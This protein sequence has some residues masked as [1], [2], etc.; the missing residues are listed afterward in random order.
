[1]HIC[2]SGGLGESTRMLKINLVPADLMQ[3]T[4]SAVVL[5]II[6]GDVYEALSTKGRSGTAQSLKAECSGLV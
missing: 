4:V 5:Y 2:K 3:Y 1:M 6:H